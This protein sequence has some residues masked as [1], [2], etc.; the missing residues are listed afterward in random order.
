MFLSLGSALRKQ[1]K[2]EEAEVILREGLELGR[3]RVGYANWGTHNIL[4]QYLG[5]LRRLGKLAE[6]EDVLAELKTMG[7]KP[8]VIPL[9]G[10]NVVGATGY[11]WAMRELVEQLQ[12]DHL[13][14]LICSDGT[15]PCVAETANAN[16]NYTSHDNLLVILR[17]TEYIAS[18][19]RI[20]H[21]GPALLRGAA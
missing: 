9:G 1:G 2:L 18:N 19:T 13:N 15:Q 3:R 20:M 5:I 4:D 8:Y 7:R 11:V 17:Y 12:R 10:S 21:D 16:L 6:A 14:V